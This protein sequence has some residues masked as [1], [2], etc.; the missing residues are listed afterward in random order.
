[1]L[2]YTAKIK[3]DLFS[4]GTWY[5][6]AVASFIVYKPTLA[7]A[8]RWAAWWL[9]TPVKGPRFISKKLCPNIQYPPENALSKGEL[10]LFGAVRDRRF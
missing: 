10:Y 9:W 2:S 3:L 6:P 4:P 5:V 1:M 7:A 8:F